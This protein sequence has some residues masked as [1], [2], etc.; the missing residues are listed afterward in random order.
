MSTST[1]TVAGKIEFADP[2]MI[3][4]WALDRSASGHHPRVQV[5]EGEELLDE[6]AASVPRWDL[7]ARGDGSSRHGFV[8]PV[9]PRM[10]DGASHELHFRIAGTDRALEASPVR[11]QETAESAWIPFTTTSLTG[12]RVL[13][14]SPHPDDESLACGGAILLHTQHGDPVR[15]V[16]LTD[17]AKADTRAE[18]TPERYIELREQEARTAAG[19][20]GVREIEFWRLPDRELS[21]SPALVD[22]LASLIEAEKPTLIYAP[23][24]LEFHPDHRAAA[25]LLWRAL[26]QA[27]FETRVAFFEYNRPV[28]V[29]ALVDIGSVIDAKR[30]ACLAYRSQATNHPYL[31]CALGLNRYRALTVSPGCEYAEGFFLLHSREMFRSPIESFALRQILPVFRFQESHEPLVSVI[32]RTKSRPGLLTEAL[33]S[34]VTQTYRNLEVIVVD[35]GGEGA[36]EVVREFARHL[37]IDYVRHPESRGRAA[38]ANTGMLRARGKYINFLDDDDLLA[39]HHIRKLAGFLEQTGEQFVYSD[40]ERVDY[41]WDDAGLAVGAN[42]RLFFGVPFDRDLLQA[43]NFIPIMTAM[44]TRSLRELSGT[45]DETLEWLEDWDLWIR[46]S[47]HAPFHH[48]PGVSAEYRV[49]VPHEHLHLSASLRVSEKLDLDSVRP[50]PFTKDSAA[51]PS[52]NP[53]ARLSVIE[54]GLSPIAGAIENERLKGEIMSLIADREW[55]KV[56]RAAL[57]QRVAV[58]ENSQTLRWALAIKRLIPGPLRSLV[59]RRRSGGPSSRA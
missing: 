3:R 40:C 50:A 28:G 11:I 29:N 21:A 55:L 31:D 42:R 41:T 48:L 5:F 43:R 8:Y 24:P 47:A 18:Y 57:Q 22:R 46:M 25:E 33:G 23:S 58:F 9:P 13:V 45:C 26:R 54:G 12:N 19:I 20:L 27:A 38:A 37:R 6:F 1:Q 36:A 10:R 35:D 49:F 16:V 39:P 14:L 2:T 53:R 52:S 17:G 34:L 56:E 30:Q 59:R 4:G 51:E 32:V 7:K 15:V 44:F